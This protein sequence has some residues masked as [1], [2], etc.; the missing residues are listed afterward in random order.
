MSD[1]ATEG[2][3]FVIEQRDEI[4]VYVGDRGHVCIKQSDG[5]GNDD[6]IVLVHPSD[7]PHLI[8]FLQRAQ[9]EAEAL[10][11]EGVSDDA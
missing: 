3:K 7:V 2:R 8:Q 6:A 1:D 10:R 11:R 5:L 9:S 4:E